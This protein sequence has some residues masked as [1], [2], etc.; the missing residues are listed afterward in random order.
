MKAAPDKTDKNMI[1]L[2]S[3]VIMD[4]ITLKKQQSIRRATID[5]MSMANKDDNETTLVL[6]NV[7]KI[8]LNLL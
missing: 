7:D 4:N 3:I 8:V 5:A 6:N 1:T 2:I